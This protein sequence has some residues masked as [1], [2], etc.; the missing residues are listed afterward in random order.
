MSN[1]T[2][3]HILSS[4][5]N[6]LGFCL[7]VITSIHVSNNHDNSNIDEFS[8]IIALILIISSVLSFISIKTEKYKIEYRLEQIADYLFLTALIGIFIILTFIILSVDSL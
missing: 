8:S 5:T 1:K 6:L 7:I 4:S 3:Q 2:S